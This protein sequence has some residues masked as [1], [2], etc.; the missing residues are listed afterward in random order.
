M[1]SRAHVRD[2]LQQHGA[3]AGRTQA[4]GAQLAQR[5]QLGEEALRAGPGSEGGIRRCTRLIPTALYLHKQ[6]LQQPREAEPL[7]C[8]FN[9][10]HG[11]IVA[12]AATATAA[13]TGQPSTFAGAGGC[14]AKRRAQHQALQGRHIQQR[15]RHQSTIT[16]RPPCPCPYT[17]HPVPQPVQRRERPAHLLRLGRLPAKESCTLKGPAQRLVQPLQR[18]EAVQRAAQGIDGLLEEA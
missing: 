5:E 1:R 4:A 8:V 6:Q 11:I 14:L 7:V 2:P 3:C 16:A 13:A 15:Q 17:R 10:P 18:L 12:A 9:I